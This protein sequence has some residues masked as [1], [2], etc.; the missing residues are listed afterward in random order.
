MRPS[1]AAANR[2]NWSAIQSLAARGGVFGK[3]AAGAE[4]DQTLVGR[5]QTLGRNLRQIAGDHRIQLRGRGL[6]GGDRGNED[7]ENDQYSTHFL[8]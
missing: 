7:R 4:G 3:R 1:D 6:G 8:T 5:A 2:R